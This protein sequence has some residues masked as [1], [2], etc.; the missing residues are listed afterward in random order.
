[1]EMIDVKDVTEELDAEQLALIAEASA[2][3]IEV[4]TPAN[5]PFVLVSVQADG[6]NLTA[7]CSRDDMVNATLAMMGCIGSDMM[8]ALGDL[9]MDEPRRQ[10]LA[11]MAGL[12]AV[13]RFMQDMLEAQSTPADAALGEA[14]AAVVPPSVH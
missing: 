1:M 6:V 5:T 11:M 2:K 7:S 3:A 10:T 8:G 12:S 14:E 4:L 13:N 9:K